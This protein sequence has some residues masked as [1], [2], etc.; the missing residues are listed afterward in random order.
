MKEELYMYD[1]IIVGA[2]ASSFLPPQAVMTSM[3][4]TRVT[5]TN[6]FFFINVILCKLC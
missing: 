6:K 1:V 4:P 5:I 3:L 2:G